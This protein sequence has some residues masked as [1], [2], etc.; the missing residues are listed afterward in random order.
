[1]PDLITGT[2]PKAAQINQPDIYSTSI[3]NSRLKQTENE[4][5]VFN[6]TEEN[7]EDS[8][9]SQSH[10]DT[11]IEPQSKNSYVLNSS[12]DFTIN[13]CA[14]FVV[15]KELIAKDSPPLKTSVLSNSLKASE[16]LSNSVENRQETPKAKMI[17][18]QKRV[19]DIPISLKTS[20]QNTATDGVDGTP[21]STGKQSNSFRTM[22]DNQTANCSPN[23]K[24]GEKQSI[25]Q[26]RT[27]A[28]QQ[29]VASSPS[30]SVIKNL[31]SMFGS[32][33]SGS[34]L[35]DEQ[36]LS[37]DK[38][39]KIESKLIYEISPDEFKDCDHRLKLYFEVSLFTGGQ[40]EFLNCL[41]KVCM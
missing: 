12:S 9:N 34:T 7:H 4:L 20:S 38:S 27:S 6:T 17:T 29:N 35:T 33:M 11:E 13:D 2:S 14:D 18:P 22:P 16:H 31:F 25:P 36:D 1:M 21:P 30:S 28:N 40:E 19:I 39:P 37:K 41:I 23:N 5:K 3:E 26:R 15:N 32:K 24:N 10:T 8:A